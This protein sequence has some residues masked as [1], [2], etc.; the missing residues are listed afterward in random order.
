MEVICTRHITLREGGAYRQSLTDA[1]L[2]IASTKGLADTR[3]SVAD[4]EALCLFL[5]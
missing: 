3:G 1:F 4:Q 2:V 5:G